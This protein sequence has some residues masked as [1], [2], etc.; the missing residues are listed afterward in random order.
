VFQVLH[1]DLKDAIKEVWVSTKQALNKILIPVNM[2]KLLELLVI[3]TFIICVPE[4]V[5]FFNKKFH[6]IGEN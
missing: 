1:I 4:I 2:V 3:G 5:N 6:E